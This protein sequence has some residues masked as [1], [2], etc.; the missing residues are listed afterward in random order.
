MNTEI[1]RIRSIAVS[2]LAV[3]RHATSRI[4]FFSRSEGRFVDGNWILL[5]R[6]CGGRGPL[7]FCVR[8]FLAGR[9]ERRTQDERENS[10]QLQPS[11]EPGMH[12]KISR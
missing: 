1:N 7:L 11:V 2:F 6:L 12:L 9:G 3:T 10:Q 5:S 4:D 8:L